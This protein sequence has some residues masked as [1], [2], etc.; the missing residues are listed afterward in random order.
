MQVLLSVQ[1]PVPEL[2]L[3]AE[4]LSLLQSPA[5]PVPPV[6]LLPVAAP[7]PYLNREQMPPVHSPPILQL[8]PPYPDSVLP[9]CIPPAPQPV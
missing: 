6:P 9:G 5:L 8:L 3:P 4:L 2:L 1:L 7:V